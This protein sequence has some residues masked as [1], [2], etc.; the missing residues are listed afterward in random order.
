MCPTQAQHL[1]II[2]SHAFL[3]MC[4]KEAVSQWSFISQVL[5]IPWTNIDI[6]AHISVKDGILHGQK[7]NVNPD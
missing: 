5:F 2:H 4:S 1:P 7:N 6:G 3:V